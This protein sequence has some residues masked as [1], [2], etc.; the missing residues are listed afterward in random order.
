MTFQ[1][2]RFRRS[3][4]RISGQ[5]LTECL[6]CGEDFSGRHSEVV[7]W[8]NFHLLSCDLPPKPSTG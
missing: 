7:A 1:P 2:K 4:D 6:G 8:E 3:G 5:L